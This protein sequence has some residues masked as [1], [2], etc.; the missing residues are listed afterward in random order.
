MHH[1]TFT[2]TMIMMI[3][4]D[5]H[6][7]PCQRACN[8]TT[9][10]SQPICYTH[11]HFREGCKSIPDTSTQNNALDF[12]LKHTSKKIYCEYP[13]DDPQQK[14]SYNEQNLSS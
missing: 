3:H 8:T 6:H 1:N 10:A 2:T 7:K 5:M 11:H 12:L 4:H 14:N 9:S 13:T